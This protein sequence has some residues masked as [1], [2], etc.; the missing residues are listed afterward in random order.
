MDKNLMTTKRGCVR[1]I[2]VVIFSCLFFLVLASQAEI[3]VKYDKNGNKVITNTPSIV[4]NSQKKAAQKQDAPTLFQKIPQAYLDKI[5]RLAL[6]YDLQ[7]KL[8]LAVAKAESDFNPTAVSR[9]GAAGIM[10]LMR[11]TAE[12]YGV[13]NRFDVDQ[14]LAAGVKHLKYLHRKYNG[15]L[16]LILAAYNAGEEAVKKYKGIPPYEE[17]RTYIKRVMNYMGLRYSG[18]FGFKRSTKIFKIVTTEGRIIITDT[19]PAKVDGVVT[20]IE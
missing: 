9:K 10:Q 14:N 2:F 1:R 6:Q 3:I 19:L 20:A 5:K 8:I 13:N 16:P 7:E 12:D 11:A 15:D 4:D 17:T 18:L